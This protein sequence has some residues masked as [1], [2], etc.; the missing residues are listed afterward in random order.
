MINLLF[1]VWNRNCILKLIIRSPPRCICLTHSEHNAT[2]WQTCGGG[3]TQP[4]SKTGFY[5][6]SWKACCKASLSQPNLSVLFQVTEDEVL[7][8]LESVLISNMSASVTRGYALTAIMKLSTRFTCTVKWVL[9]DVLHRALWQICW[10]QLSLVE[11]FL[12]H[13]VLPWFT[14]VIL[15]FVLQSS[16]ACRVED[17][18]WFILFSLWMYTTM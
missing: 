7:D 11:V 8:I 6:V 1:N 17:F 5:S 10:H 15:L 16:F 2:G 14:G 4:L 9:I 13:V 3:T 12:G 18:H